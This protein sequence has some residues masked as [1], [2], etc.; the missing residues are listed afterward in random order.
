MF[1]LPLK[2]TDALNLPA[3]LPPSDPAAAP[4]VAP[5][6]APALS[7]AIASVGAPMATPD[8]ATVAKYRADQTR[9]IRMG[10]QEL[11]HPMHDQYI[12]VPL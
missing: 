5:S 8:A 3:I 1:P 6:P 7:E 11:I 4:E 9:A 2:N 10:E 12:R